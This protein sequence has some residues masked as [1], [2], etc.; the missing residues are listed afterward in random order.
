MKGAGGRADAS[1]ACLRII[2]AGGNGLL[3]SAAGC[4]APL[5]LLFAPAARSTPCSCRAVEIMDGDDDDAGTGR[6]DWDAAGRQTRPPRDEGEREERSRSC[7]KSLYGMHVCMPMVFM[8]FSTDRLIA[9]Y[10]WAFDF[11][12]TLQALGLSGG[13]DAFAH[14]AF[15]QNQS[16]ML[17]SGQI[18][19]FQFDLDLPDS[20]GVARAPGRIQVAIVGK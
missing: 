12:A 14:S 2:G 4:D 5:L 3:P 9:S 20:M 10:R 6:D 15:T 18:D 1:A 8:P 19:V 17:N 7:V 11:G 16:Q 13:E